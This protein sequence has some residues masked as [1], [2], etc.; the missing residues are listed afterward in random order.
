MWNI[1][2]EST[3]RF[4]GFGID[5]HEL[6]RCVVCGA[7]TVEIRIG[8]C[9]N[10]EAVTTTLDDFPGRRLCAANQTDTAQ[11]D[12]FGVGLKER[13]FDVQSVLD[14]HESRVCICRREGGLN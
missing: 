2:R 10:E 4:P 8:E 5:L 1:G 12:S 6:A 13:F 14:E 9:A 11:N 7:G 3:V